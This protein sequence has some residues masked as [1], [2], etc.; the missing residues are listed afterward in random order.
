MSISF[1]LKYGDEVQ[2]GDSAFHI[3]HVVLSR[4]VQFVVYDCR[5]L[6]AAS[7]RYLLFIGGDGCNDYDAG[8]YNN[9]KLNN[10][11]LFSQEHL[12]TLS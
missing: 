8:V 4:D 2:L 9:N 12:L 1:A 10:C 6:N 3:V 7:R 11:L 5:K